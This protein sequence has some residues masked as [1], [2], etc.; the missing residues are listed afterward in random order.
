MRTIGIGN[1]NFEVIRKENY[2]YIDKTRFIQ[3]WWESGDH[4]TLITRPRRFGKTLNMTMTEE[5]FS[6]QYAGREDL[7]QGLAIWENE[8]FRLLQGTYPVISFSF[9]HSIK[10]HTVNTDWTTLDRFSCVSS[11]N[12][13]LL[14]SRKKS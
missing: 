12:S 11:D 9:P 14:Y 1:Q 6:V 7:F 13:F 3:M 2:F 5:F 10:I 8:K 4:V